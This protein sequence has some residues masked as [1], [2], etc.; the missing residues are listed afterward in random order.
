MFSMNA[1]SVARLAA[2][3]TLWLAAGACAD[4][5]SAPRAPRMESARTIGAPNEGATMSRAF[6]RASRR[7][8]RQPDGSLLKIETLAARDGRLYVVESAM[9]RDG[10]PRETKVSRDGQ[11]IARLVNDWTAHVSGYTL[12]RQRLVRFAADGTTQ[13]FDSQARGGIAQMTGADIVIPKP[14][15]YAALNAAPVLRQAGFRSFY[16]SDD[17]SNDQWP[18]TGPCDDKARAVDAALDNWLVSIAAL[19]GATLNGNLLAAFGAWTYEVKAWRDFTRA[20]DAL[21]QCVAD[22]GKKKGDDF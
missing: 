5:P 21:D 11:V 1:G 13:E 8:V 12:E 2:G 20:E 10:L 7:I 4:A 17:S 3:V 9:D 15:V 19:G 14:R 16:G 18:V 22:A 6:S